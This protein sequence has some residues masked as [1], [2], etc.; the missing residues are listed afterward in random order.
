MSVKRVPSPDAGRIK[1]LMRELNDIEAQAGWFASSKYP[2][3]TPVAYVA[4]IQEF[5]YGP[6]PP[7]SFMRPTVAAQ[8]DRWS[9]IAVKMTKTAT[10]GE[11]IAEVMGATMAGDFR[12]AIA[13]LT[14]PPLAEE[15]LYARKHRKNPPPNN[16]EKPLVDTRVMLP[17]LTHVVIKGGK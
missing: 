6:I 3:G 17:T 15:T 4:S 10:S 2:D 11:A 13:E 9:K 14:T 12:E 5:G 8:K 7:R 16:S 1:K